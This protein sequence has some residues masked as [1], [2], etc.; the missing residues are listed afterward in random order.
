M[1]Y[2][3]LFTLFCSFILLLITELSF[4][5][6]MITHKQFIREGDKLVSSS[7]SFELGFFS[8]GNSNSRYLGI[9]YKI[10][11]ETVVWVANRK[12]PIP[13]RL[14]ALTISDNGSLVLIN[15]N[16]SIILSSNSSKVPENPVAQ[17]LDS[18]NLVLRD[19]ND[20]S[21]E[22]Y[23]WQS[24]DYPSDTLL[25][26][27]KLGWNLKTGFER[28]LTPWKSEDDPSPG[29][30]SLRLDIRGVP[31]LVIGTP[32]RKWAR[33]GPWNGLQFGGI[34]LM[35]NKIFKPILVQKE[36]ELYYAWEPF[37]DTV[38]T[39]LSLNSS[40]HMQR[41]VWD[42]RIRE[43]SIVFSWPYD[44]CDNYAQCG[45]NAYCRTSKTL[46]CICL[47]GFESK[48]QDEWDTPDT[49]KCVKKSPI[50]SDCQNGE[51]FQ[52]LSRMKLPDVNWSNQNM[53]TK[54]CYAECLKNC[55]CRAYAALI[56]GG[57]SSGCMMWFTD[58]VDMKQCSKRFTWGQDIFIRVPAS[59]LAKELNK[60]KRIK[61]FVSV[62][63][64][65]GILILGFVFWNVWKKTKNRG[66][67]FISSCSFFVDAMKFIWQPLYFG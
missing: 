63:T 3:P 58:L 31:Q 14:G 65:C 46:E 7:R 17:L 15:K 66:N 53:N 62:S 4:A 64:V 22:S 19:S 1:K 13:D 34:P 21:P 29:E 38:I 16:K 60:K 32:S 51:G 36:D 57:G 27:M 30:S 18:G 47:K 59:E 55:S 61:I 20:M 49:V 10:S 67:T 2:L 50:E 6:D 5:A 45:A 39:R 12:D 26:G 33:S 23:I 37:D 9:W 52:K 28:R 25:E 42:E 35:N 54:E 11:P 24:F 41:H 44:K 8:P 43:W 48:S 56:E 40:G